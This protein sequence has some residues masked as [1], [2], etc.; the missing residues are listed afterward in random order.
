[1]KV[2]HNGVLCMAIVIIQ[3]IND[4]FSDRFWPKEHLLHFLETQFM[5]N[6][7]FHGAYGQSRAWLKVTVCVTRSWE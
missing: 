1:V 4:P 7:N 6:L 5:I 2:I 3:T